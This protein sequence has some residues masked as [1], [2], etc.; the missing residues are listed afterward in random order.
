MPWEKFVAEREIPTN[1]LQNVVSVR[2]REMA[3]AY[4]IVQKHF[5]KNGKLLKV[6]IF[7]N[8]ATG[9]I[10]LHPNQSGYHLRQRDKDRKGAYILNARNFLKVNP[11]KKGR[12]EPRWDPDQ[13]F[14]IIK[15]WDGGR[16]IEVTVIDEAAQVDFCPECE[17]LGFKDGVCPHCGYTE[18]LCPKGLAP[19]EKEEE[20]CR[21]C[22]YY[23]RKWG[24]HPAMCSWGGWKL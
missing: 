24:D 10:G 14:L 13:E 16:S 22:E 21:D 19:L 2:A 17:E 5:I 6:Q 4:D 23:K 11:L 20:V 15:V 9:E 8:K 18:I 3:L 12:Y 7:I 1:R